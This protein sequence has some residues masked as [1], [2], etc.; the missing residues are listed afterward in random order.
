MA[1]RD[2]HVALAETVRRDSCPLR[3]SFVEREIEEEPQPTPLTALLRTQDLAGG[4][5]GGLRIS[6]L[7]T[8]IWVNARPPYATRR[9][10]A[11]WA[12]LLGRED[13]RGEGAR[14]VRDAL[15][16]L[17]DRGLI[18]LHS[19][20]PSTEIILCNESRPVDGDRPRAYTPPYGQ[21]PYIQVPRTFWT[22]G[23]AGRL[24]G[25]GVAMYLC[26]L[27]MT[28]HDDPEFFIS[29]RFFEEFFGIS[30][31]SRKRGLTE[32]TEHGVLTVRVEETVSMSTFRR[33][34]RNVYR[35]AKRYRQPEAWRP[36]EEDGASSSVPKAEKT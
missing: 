26:A 16:E 14:A 11:Y 33:V 23:L 8:L 1:Y 30:R 5:G 29:A 13:P 21:E 6:L 28:R 32:L 4:K 36:D 19:T 31:S 18:V 7:L 12:E 17:D 35:I 20:G 25:A 3:R 10:A 34:K 24:T 27:A 9:V 22:E 15:H 2:G